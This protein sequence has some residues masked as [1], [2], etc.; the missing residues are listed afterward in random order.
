M[1]KLSDDAK[2]LIKGIIYLF[3]FFV[4]LHGLSE[5]AHAD[6]TDGL[7]SYGQCMR[8]MKTHGDP[9]IHKASIFVSAGAGEGTDNWFANGAWD[10]GVLY[11]AGE[12]KTRYATDGTPSQCKNP[13]QACKRGQCKYVCKE[14]VCRWVA[15][16]HGVQSGSLSKAS[17]KGEGRGRRSHGASG[18]ISD[19]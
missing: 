17:Y 19:F 5:N 8:I 9:C 11:F 13:C 10:G 6:D 14:H 12:R 18:S 15:A 2:Y 4:A 1:D 7:M 16:D 3:L